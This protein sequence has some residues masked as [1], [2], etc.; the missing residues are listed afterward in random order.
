MNLE[1]LPASPPSQSE[2]DVRR[3]KFDELWLKAINSSGKATSNQHVSSLKIELERCFC[4][5]AWVACVILSSSIVEVYLSGLVGGWKGEMAANLLD[6]LNVVAEWEELKKRRNLLIH[7]EGA[8]SKLRRLTTDEYR[9]QRHTLEIEAERS[10][11]LALRVTLSKA[12]NE[13]GCSD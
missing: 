8:N 13:Q 4:S 5:G 11:E 7:G 2:W 10:I 1:W 6:R 9:L 3:E 12:Y